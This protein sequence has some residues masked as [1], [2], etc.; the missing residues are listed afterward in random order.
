MVITRAGSRPPTAGPA[1]RFTGAVTVAPSFQ[2]TAYARASAAYVTFE[3]GARS[4]WHMHPAGQ[5]LVTAGVGWI[6]QVGGDKHEIRVGDVVWTPPGVT[7][8][9]G[10]TAKVAMTHLAIQEQSADQTVEWRERVDDDAYG[11]PRPSKAPPP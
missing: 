1:E 2:P 9:H 6:Q 10:A 7:H 11:A 8:W 4:A 3:P 5:M